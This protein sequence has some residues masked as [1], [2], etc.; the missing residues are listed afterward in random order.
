MQPNALQKLI[1]NHA[2]AWITT[3]VIAS[4][5]Q[6]IHMEEQS[7]DWLL[8]LGLPMI[9]WLGFALNDYYDTDYD[10]DDPNKAQGNYFLQSGKSK[11]FLWIAA[12]LIA[13]VTGVG[14]LRYGWTTLWIIIPSASVMFAYSA[15]PLR[16]KSRPGFDLLT[17]ALFVQTYPYGVSLILSGLS[18]QPVD[19]A[20]LTILFCSSLTAQLEQQSRDYNVDL[21]NDYN[22]TILVGKHAGL[23]A[24]KLI[25]VILISLTIFLV[26]IGLLPL[27]TLPLFLCSAPAILH[28]LYRPEHTPRSE[29]LI[30]RLMG[31]AFVYVLILWG[32]VFVIG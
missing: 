6:L 17:H 7:I 25:T 21:A 13:L 23:F 31:L 26:L 10:A 19:Y 30:R 22:F 24:L 8:V 1:F 29:W 14:L 4:V 11:Q 5:F 18:A 27:F 9:Y 16:L 15:P 3:F 28:R 12:I 2:D 20:V 32:T